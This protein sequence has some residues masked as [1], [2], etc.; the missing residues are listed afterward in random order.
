MGIHKKN[1]INNPVK[2]VPERAKSIPTFTTSMAKKS[3]NNKLTAA[4]NIKNEIMPYRIRCL[5]PSLKAN[6]EIQ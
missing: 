3:A 6:Q 5:M 2:E 4:T 1:K